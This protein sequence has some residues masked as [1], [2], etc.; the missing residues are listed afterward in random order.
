MGEAKINTWLLEERNVLLI[1]KKLKEYLL[2]TPFFICE[3]YQ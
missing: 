3:F 2:L 1:K